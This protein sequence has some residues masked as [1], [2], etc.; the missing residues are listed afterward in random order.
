VC[1][2]DLEGYREFM[3]NQM[4]AFV[5]NATTPGRHQQFHPLCTLSNGYDSPTVAVLA[6][7]YGRC[8]EAVSIDVDREG[9]PDNGEAIAKHLGMT[10]TLISREVWRSLDQPEI[11]FIAG[12][13]GGSDVVLAAAERYLAGT[14]LFTGYNGTG[15]WGKHS[16]DGKSEF[17]RSDGSGRSLT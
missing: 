2:S 17:A 3:G 6:R 7:H 1:S 15:A 14:V 11:P 8:R 9:S 4:Q 16:K 5:T 12:T 10:C 13:P